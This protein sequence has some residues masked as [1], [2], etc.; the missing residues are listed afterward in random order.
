MK[1]ALIG[2]TGGTGLQ[3]IDQAIDRGHHVVAYCRRPDA[4][5]PRPGLTIVGGHLDDR[6]AL[7]AALS[8]ADAVLCTIGPKAGLAGMFGVT[9]M[10]DNLPLITS[11]MR[12]AHID[13]LILLSAY[14]VG[15][16]ART[17]SP[18]ARFA[19]KTLV[20]SAYRDKEISETALAAAGLDVTRVLPV[21]LDDGP[22]NPHATVRP[23][24][25]VRKVSGLPKVSRA[26]VAAAILDAAESGATTGERLLVSAPGTIS[27]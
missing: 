2:A 1:L 9:V 14:G 5:T 10:Q 7:A 13:R 19:Y 11:A 4:L 15:D 16:T 23:M 25:T 22:L 6:D 3:I 17:A 12:D 21:I 18:L 26:T 8:G 24:S 27:G 20:A